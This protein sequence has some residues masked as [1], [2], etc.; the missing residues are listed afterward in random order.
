MDIRVTPKD[1]SR[2]VAVTLGLAAFSVAGWAM[3]GGIIFAAGLPLML[4]VLLVVIID[5]RHKI[6][7]EIETQ[8]KR[9]FR[10]LDALLSIHAFIQGYQPLPS[11]RG[12]AASP[13]LLRILIDLIDEHQP[14]FIVEAGSG[15]STIVMGHRLKQIGGGR[16]LSFDHEIKYAEKTQRHITQHSLESICTVVHAPLT[17]HT[18]HEKKCPWYTLNSQIHESIDLLFVDGPPYHIGTMARY[19]ALPLLRSHLSNDA[20]VVI[21][22]GDRQEER[23]IVERWKDEYSLDATYH[24]TE[25]GAYILRGGD[26]SAHNYLC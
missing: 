13:D 5:M 23:Q 9:Q 6:T 2:I 10:Q 22:D 7:S 18:L 12:W 21:D 24:N 14:Q 11:T 20:L 15:V 1:W 16:I 8:N 17:E 4:A 3:W 25:K 19:P 26:E